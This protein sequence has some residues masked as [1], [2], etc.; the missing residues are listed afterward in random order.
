[1][2]G[3]MNF[4]F[5]RSSPNDLG[6]SRAVFFGAMF[7]CFSTHSFKDWAN[8]SRV[9]WKPH[10]FFRLFRIPLLGYTTLFALEVAWKILLFMACLGLATR[11]TVAGSFLIGLYL[12]GLPNCFMKIRHNDGLPV[13]IMGI[14]AFSRCGDGFSLDQ[15]LF[16]GQLPSAPS[17]GGGDYT[18]PVRMIWLI[19]SL[20]LFATGYAKIKRSGLAWANSGNLSVTLRSMHYWSGPKDPLVNWGLWIAEQPVLCWLL[21]IFT[22]VLEFGFPLALFWPG[23]RWFFVGGGFLMLLSFRFLMGM[24]FL[25]FAICQFFWVPWERLWMMIR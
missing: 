24:S 23:V 6:I 20:T 17:G 14:L 19:I 22:L 15:L 8:V 16:S 21:G 7:L 9:F 3:W 13:L 4:W 18:W 10:T 1:M 2:S 5:E 12:L 25:T 11:F